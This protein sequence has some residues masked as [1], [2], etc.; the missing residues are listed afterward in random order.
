MISTISFKLRDKF[1]LQKM[2]TKRRM[3]ITMETHEITIVRFGQ[4]PTT[5]IFC[6]VC[7]ADIPHLSVTQASAVLSL[8]KAE[9]SRLIE[10]KQIH[11]T[12]NADG[13]EQLC[14]NSLSAL[15]KEI[16]PE[17]DQQSVPK[18]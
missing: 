11:L 1:R 13:D 2:K 3:E 10:N 16:Y 4:R 12:E 7:Q 6:E 14:G 17:T 18:K 9:I 5:T 15:T 8:S